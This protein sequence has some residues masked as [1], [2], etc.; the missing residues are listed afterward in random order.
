MG[1]I[2]KRVDVNIVYRKTGETPYILNGSGFA[3]L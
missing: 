2:L 3:D 1:E